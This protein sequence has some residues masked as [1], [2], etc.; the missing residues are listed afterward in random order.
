MN[1]VLSSRAEEGSKERSSVKLPT[2]FDSTEKD[3]SK[4]ASSSAKPAIFNDVAVVPEVTLNAPRVPAG[5]LL[6]NF[7]GQNPNTNE[8]SP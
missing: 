7:F 4:G 3:A 8:I 5:H 6:K 2:K 1:E